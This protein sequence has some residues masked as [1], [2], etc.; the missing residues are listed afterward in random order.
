LRTTS[1]FAAIARPL[2]L[3]RGEHHED[4]REHIHE[5]EHQRPQRCPAGTGHTAV[6]FPDHLYPQQRLPERS[7]PE[8]FRESDVDG[9]EDAKQEHDHEQQYQ[10]Q[11][12]PRSREQEWREHRERARDERTIH[13]ASGHPSAYDVAILRW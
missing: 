2:A 12:Q 9:I 4:T 1:V 8:A 11:D 7:S 3:R 5:E 6:F 10:N 13:Q